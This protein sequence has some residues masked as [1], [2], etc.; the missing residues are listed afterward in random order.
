MKM[1][2][3]REFFIKKP[4][5]CEKFTKD[6][7]NTQIVEPLFD[8]LSSDEQLVYLIKADNDDIQRFI[9]NFFTNIVGQKDE[10]AL[11]K[12]N[13]KEPETYE[14]QFNSFNFYLFKKHLGN[15]LHGTGKLNHREV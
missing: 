13:L 6:S 15:V 14:L 3:V 12:K 2:E 8:K 4:A 9:S 10:N 5:L 7:I 1:E 11:I